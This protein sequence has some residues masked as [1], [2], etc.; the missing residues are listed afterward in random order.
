MK[1]KANIPRPLRI[2]SHEILVSL[3]PLLL[4]ITT[5]HTLQTNTHALDIMYR[6]PA[7]AVEQVE[8]D[9]AVG[10]DVWVPGYGARVGADEGDFW[11]LRSSRSV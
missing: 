3:R 4:I 10:V 2:I 1:H 11:G 6:G 8:T 7:R 9:D 5:E